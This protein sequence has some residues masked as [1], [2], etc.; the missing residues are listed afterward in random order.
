MRERLESIASVLQKS[1]SNAPVASFLKNYVVQTLPDEIIP[2]YAEGLIESDDIGTWLS[3]NTKLLLDQS[4]YIFELLLDRL[5]PSEQFIKIII[6]ALKAL[7]SKKADDRATYILEQFSRKCM[8]LSPERWFEAFL[9]AGAHLAAGCHKI[10]LKQNEQTA[11]KLLSVIPI[12]E[13]STI[14]AASPPS[15][16]SKSYGI[17]MAD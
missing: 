7:K 10:L 11:E 2:L 1:E 16:I 6:G 15:W 17:K 13:F 9:D 4:Q 8:E 5:Y 12:S 3:E 14:A